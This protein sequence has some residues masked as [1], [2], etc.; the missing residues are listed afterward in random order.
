MNQWQNFLKNLGEWRGS[1]TQLTPTGKI[2]KSTPS[3]LSLEGFEDNRLVRFRLRRYD[4]PDYQDP[5][6]Q[7]YSQEYRSLGRQIIFFDTG[8]FSKGAWQLAPFTEFGAE[9]GFIV[10]DRRMRFVQLYSKELHLDSLTLIREFRAGSD[11]QERPQLTVEQLLGTWQGKAYTVSPNWPEP[12]MTE[13][14]VTLAQEGDRLHQTSTF[15]EATINSTGVIQRDQIR[16]TGHHARSVLLLPDGVSCNAPDA[17]QLR[18][19]FFLEVGWLV[20]NHERQRLLRHYDGKGGWSGS[21]LVV[22][23]RVAAV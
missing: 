19:S 16:F 8:T 12:T 21:T 10:G 13:T 14:Q 7:D 2:I 9:F 22:E 23:Q 15:N 11:A 1:F 3:I 4:N 20:S 18:Q 17:L 5:P 6:T